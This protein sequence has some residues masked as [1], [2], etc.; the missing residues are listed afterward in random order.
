MQI[1]DMLHQYNRNLANGV[2]MKSGT[3][4][5]KQIT[6]TLQQMSVGNVFEGSINSIEDGVVT[7]GL[8]DGKTIQAKLDSGV[9]VRPGESMFFQV[10]SNNGEQIAIRPFSNGIASNPT[11]I[12]ALE[13]ANLQVNAK[14]LTMV[15]TMME[16]SMAID[17]QS[18]MQ[19]ARLIMGNDGANPA[20]IVQMAKLGIPVTNEMVAQFENYK[21]DQYAILQDMESMMSELPGKLSSGSMNMEQILE[22]NRQITDIF[23]GGSNTGE[24]AQVLQEG[25]VTVS[26]GT[27]SGDGRVTVQNGVVSGDGRTVL[28]DVLVTEEGN[29]VL[30][31]ADA[32]IK[33][34]TQ[35]QT[36]GQV[37]QNGPVSIKGEASQQTNSAVSSM[38]I[39]QL[40]GNKEMLQ[41]SEQLGK[42]PNLAEN[43]AIFT[44]GKLNQELTAK[45]LL[46]AL[47]QIFS[48]K[49]ALT[50]AALSEFVSGKNYRSLVRS[51]ME[52]QWLLRPQ[53]LQSEHKV[54]ELYS[55]LN[56]QLEQ[57]ENVLKNFGQQ[58]SRL[59]DTA[60][61]VRSNIS[62]MNQ[63]NQT[64]AYVQLPLKL[65]GQNAHSD[66]YVYTGGRRAGNEEGEFTA[67][68]H[69]DLEH[70]GSTDVSVR[71]RKK[72]VTTNFYL[73]DDA[74][75]DLVMKH[76]DI[77]EERLAKKGYSAKIQVNTQEEKVSFVDELLKKDQPL[78]GGM[79]HRYSFDVRA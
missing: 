44:D 49:D 67:F 30:Q 51:V 18:L 22:F 46:Q 1:T 5:I 71:M 76:M 69:L 43:P 8:S 31:N 4:G 53:D 52:E 38:T 36:A 74:S 20:T 32:S 13:A 47:N 73:A 40:L 7:L 26:D 34:D 6:S 72:S 59:S 25:T 64:F 54:N 42:I 23:L 57:M 62:F 27:I 79:V 77:L 24:E 48:S 16:Q 50:K 9:T 10:K 66:L 65:S 28:Q 63:I 33:N 78:A 15:N 17:K 29:V 11:L 55:R 14:M 12:N 75:Y 35:A 60:A 19:M 56:S 45:E 61:G 70:L 58:N 2:E 37:A 68:L 21:S 39:E 41:L 3:Q